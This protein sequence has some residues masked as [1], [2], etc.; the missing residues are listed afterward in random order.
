MCRPKVSLCM[1]IACLTPVKHLKGVLQ[2]L[3]TYGDVIYEPEPSRSTVRN[4]L[5]NE[6]VDAI[7]TNPNKLGFML[8]KDV[9][10]YTQVKLI[11][12]ASTGTN[13]IDMD[14]CRENGIEVM[15]LTTDHELLYQLPSTSELAFGLFLCLARRIIPAHD[16]VVSEGAWDYEPFMGR[17]IQGMNAGIVGYGRLGKMMANYCNAFGMNVRVCDPYVKEFVPYG[18]V[19][20]DELLS[21]SDMISLHVHVNDETRHMISAKE[22]MAMKNNCLLVNTAR[23]ELVD[24]ESV[25][26]GLVLGQLGG[27]GTDVLASEFSGDCEKNPIRYAALRGYNVV[28]T[29]HV[30]GMSWEGQRLAFMHA[31]DKFQEVDDG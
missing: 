6:R 29:P 5:I 24:E 18:R 1:R 30:G 4:L 13:H 16:S 10:E 26:H 8:Q 11:N 31:V 20:M 21:E 17:Q 28:I 15:S 22:I 27:Y 23:G 3:K 7:F 9:L 12:T 2:R 19:S 25:R 14:Y